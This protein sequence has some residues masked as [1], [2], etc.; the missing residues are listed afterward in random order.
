MPIF[1]FCAGGWAALR[2]SDGRFR[3]SSAAAGDEDRI[4]DAQRFDGSALT[5]GPYYVLYDAPGLTVGEAER[6]YVALKTAQGW[7]TYIREV[8]C[9]KI[10]LKSSF[11]VPCGKKPRT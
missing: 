6:S 2:C 11:S 10:R 8:N 7:G 3:R 1:F 4:A 5:A 9:G